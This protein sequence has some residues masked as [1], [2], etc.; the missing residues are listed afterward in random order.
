VCYSTSIFLACSVDDFRNS[1]SEQ[2]KKKVGEVSRMAL[3]F[4]GLRKRSMFFLQLI[5]E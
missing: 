4:G 5:V 2:R 3:F 1:K